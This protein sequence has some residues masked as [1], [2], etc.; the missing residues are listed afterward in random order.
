MPRLILIL[1]GLACMSGCNPP[2]VTTPTQDPIY[3]PVANVK[4]TME[5]ILDPAADVIWDSAGFIVT[6]D[7]EED[8]SPTTE[9]GWEWVRRN[10]AV[11]AEAGNLLMMPG[12]AVGPDWV[13]QAQALV[14]AG[15]GAMAAAEARDAVALFDA[16]GQIYQ[17]CRACHARFLIPPEQAGG[18]R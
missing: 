14:R 12:R 13:A 16:G 1:V 5:W 8:L 15:E 7:G 10:A 18:T 4:Q 9:E 17:V 11:V 2:R 6:A 3:R